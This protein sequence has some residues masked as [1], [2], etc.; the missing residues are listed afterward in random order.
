MHKLKYLL[1][2]VIFPL[3]GFSQNSIYVNVALGGT[4]PFTDSVSVIFETFAF[5]TGAGISGITLDTYL[6]L[7]SIN[8]VTPSPDSVL[9]ENA[10]GRVISLNIV[11]IE[12]LGLAPNAIFDNIPVVLLPE[13]STDNLLGLDVLSKFNSIEINFITQRVIFE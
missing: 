11:N 13:S 8:A 4:N 10:D 12:F 1:L 3:I 9:V 7:K 5:D 6:N 2:T